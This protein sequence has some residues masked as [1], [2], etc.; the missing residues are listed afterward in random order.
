MTGFSLSL[1]RPLVDG[2]RTSA[3]VS[4][5]VILRVLAEWAETPEGHLCLVENES[6]G[7]RGLQAGCLT[8]GTV[9]V[10][11]ARATAADDVVT[12]VAHAPLVS[13]RRAGG[14]DAPDQFGDEELIEGVVH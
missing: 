4:V 2:V 7:V 14:L 13:G 8:D 10:G 5:M 12:V 9:D 1:P 3:V 6:V 11:G